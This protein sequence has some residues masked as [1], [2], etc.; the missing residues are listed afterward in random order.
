[1]ESYSVEAAAQLLRVDPVRIQD[2]IN[3]KLVDLEEDGTISKRELLKIMDCISDDPTSTDTEVE[4][5]TQK[6]KAEKKADSQAKLKTKKDLI[7]VEDPQL[8]EIHQKA[9]GYVNRAQMTIEFLR[10]S[11]GKLKRYKKIADGADAE[12]WD[13]AK[14]LYP[15]ISGEK[16]FV[17][18]E[19]EDGLLI[20][21]PD[22]SNSKSGNFIKAFQKMVIKGV[23]EGHIP[24][25]VAMALGI[26]PTML[27]G[28]DGDDE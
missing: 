10:R 2:L 24:P 4:T 16:T 21:R 20:I 27:Q 8:I 28:D 26:N 19:T 6:K 17:R 14:K 5:P 9:M 18:E 3:Q 1:M 25:H 22:A 23:Q 7:L 13:R 11:E 12:F 15:Q